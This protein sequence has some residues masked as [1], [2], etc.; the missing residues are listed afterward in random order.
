[1]IKGPVINRHFPP[2]A[3]LV[4]AVSALVEDASGNPISNAT[5][6]GTWTGGYSGSAACTTD[7]SGICGVN[8]GNIKTDF[9]L[10]DFTVENIAHPSGS[11]DPAA[12]HDPDG[13]SDGTRITVVKP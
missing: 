13:D 10:V 9:A 8:T 1:M 7:A 2:S 4:A 12:N 11:Y 3:N 5:V 6:T